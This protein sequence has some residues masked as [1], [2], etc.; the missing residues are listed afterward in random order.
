MEDKDSK[1]VIRIYH[2]ASLRS[3]S[4]VLIKERKEEIML[5][6]IKKLALAVLGA[7]ALIGTKA[8]KVFDEL[9]KKG[10]VRGGKAKTIIEELIKKGKVSQDK[11]K[12]LFQRLLKGPETSKKVM[13]KEVKKALDEKIGTEINRAIKELD[14]PTKEDFKALNRK[15]V[16]LAKKL[17][18]DKTSKEKEEE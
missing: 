11:G 4:D 6:F 12:E 15:L 17:S 5:G 14:I 10:E 16:V 7:G 8:K 13:V 3:L 1:E 18:E 2:L 9:V